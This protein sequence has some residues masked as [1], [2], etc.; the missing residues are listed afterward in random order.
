VSSAPSF[1]RAYKLVIPAR[2]ASTRLPRKM[3][4]PLAGKP[5]VQWTWEAACRTAA[6]EVIVAVDD[7]ETLAVCR[8]F[9]AD[10]RMT[11]PSLNSGTDRVDAIAREAGWRDDMLVI[12]LQGDEPLM[13][14]SLV[15]GLAALLEDDLLAD[16]ATLAH[17]IH[18][19][20]EFVDP[21]VVKVVTADNGYALYF[22]RAP[23][24]FL[25]GAAAGELPPGGLAMRHIGLY[26]YRTAALRR[27]AG[28]PPAALENCEALEQLR[29]LAHGLHIRVGSVQ[30]PPPRG[31]DVEADLETAARVLAAQ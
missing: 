15:D 22:S 3:L 28:L 14:P 17:P 26:G 27:M 5:L 1:K 31:V 10:A 29:A 21:N 2:L 23:I 7:A 24:P 20:A 4:R 9:G 12:N 19:H 11:D 6:E 25:R 30:T 13:P 8:G 16:I 18:D